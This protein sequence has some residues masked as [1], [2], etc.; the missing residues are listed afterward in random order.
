[1]MVHGALGRLELVVHIV[2]TVNRVGLLGVGLHFADALDRV[3]NIAVDIRHADADLTKDPAQPH[4]ED[5]APQHDDRHRNQHDQPHLPVHDEHEGEG[6]N[7]QTDRDKQILWPVMRQLTDRE[8]IVRDARHN[9]PGLRVVEVAEREFLQVTEEIRAHVGLNAGAED[10]PPLHVDELC[11][12][13]Q[14][15]QHTDDADRG[16][17]VP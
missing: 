13:H 10:M 16:P 11:Q 1:M 12:G 5:I 17:D 7:Q 3:F 9:V 15:D 6:S 8:E 14:H 4:P 2:E